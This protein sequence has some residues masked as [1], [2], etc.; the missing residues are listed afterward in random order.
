MQAHEYT[1]DANGT[2][3]QS[4]RLDAVRHNGRLIVA[5]TPETKWISTWAEFR[6]AGASMCWHEDQSGAELILPAPY[7]LSIQFPATDAGMLAELR[8]AESFI[9]GFE[10]DELQEGIGDLLSGIRAAIAKAEG[11]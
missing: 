9:S 4:V 5:T 7:K 11:N 3:R 2:L 6:A 10:G 1:K 8:K